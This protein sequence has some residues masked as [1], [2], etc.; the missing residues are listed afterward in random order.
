MSLELTSYFILLA[1]S[2]ICEVTAREWRWCA[3][4]IRNATQL[5]QDDWRGENDYHDNYLG[6]EY[7]W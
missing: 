4:N 6:K 5:G 1:I 2:V 7:N 3:Y